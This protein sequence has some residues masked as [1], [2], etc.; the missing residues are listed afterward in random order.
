MFDYLLSHPQE[1]FTKTGE[2]LYLTFCALSMAIFLGIPLGLIAWHYK[3]L[4]KWLLGFV[5]VIQTVPSLALF[6]CI[7]PMPFIGGIGAK[8]AILVLLLYSLL[9]IVKNTIVGLKHVSHS[10]IEA[11]RGIGMTRTQ[12]L[13]LV[14][15][16]DAFPV[17]MG[18]IRLATVQIIGTVTIAAIIGAGGLGELIYRGTSMVDY[19]LLM[20]G[21]LPVILLAILADK[22]LEYVEKHVK[23]SKLMRLVSF[24]PHKAFVIGCF[25]L[26]CLIFAGAAGGVYRAFIKPR[27]DIVVGVK[28]TTESRLI[29]ELVR[30]HIENEMKIPVHTVHLSSTQLAFQALLNRNIDCYME[31]SGTAYTTF[32]QCKEKKSSDDV[33]QTVKR[34]LRE[35]Y[36]IMTLDPL[37]FN[38]TYV[39]AL[40]KQDGEKYHIKTLADLR[41]YAPLFKIGTTSEFHDRQDG[42]YGLK[43]CYGLRF[44]DECILEP[45]LRYKALSHGDVDLIDAFTTDGQLDP[46]NFLLLEDADHFFP[47]Y[48]AVFLMNEK[49][50]L[51]YPLLES[52]LSMLCHTID[53]SA[54]RMM[55]YQVEIL[56]YPVEQVV[57]S[58]VEKNK[59]MN[60]RRVAFKIDFHM[61]A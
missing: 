56:K 20:A 26:L 49:A 33:R 7:I 27:Q 22:L 6:G 14:I 1:L 29:A 5:N 54:M 31:Y 44:R 16:P 50:S 43:Q 10:L 32:L 40:R 13:C 21:T 53:E 23:I 2:H 35:K 9:P 18:G 46:E 52:V 41:R 24:T 19:G 55:N 47:P 60:H 30:S 11:A 61:D 48:D 25:C 4:G 59:M 39:M 3:K 38:N 12:Q 15:I 37:G 8:P 57:H 51:T 28:N 45:A 34:E 42:L 36:G 58:F 17:L